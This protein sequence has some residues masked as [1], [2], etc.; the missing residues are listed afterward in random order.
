MIA[1]DTSSLIAYLSGASGRDV[2]LVDRALLDGQVYL[3][4]VVVTELISDP[5]LPE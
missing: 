2:D 4:P 3:A 5:K 1:V